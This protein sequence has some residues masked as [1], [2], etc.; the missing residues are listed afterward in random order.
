VFA[1]HARVRSAAG[2]SFAGSLHPRLGL[3]SISTP[4]RF[5]FVA[6]FERKKK[7]EA[8]IKHH[9]VITTPL[10]YSDAL[11]IGEVGQCNVELCLSR[12]IGLKA[13][14]FKPFPLL[15][16]NPG[17]QKRAFQMQPAPLTARWTSSSSAAYATRSA[18]TP[19]TCAPRQG[20][21]TLSLGL[22]RS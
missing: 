6:F 14:G 21:L 13:T 1:R 9:M 17:F 18:A 3:S 2:R 5:S 7:H 16:T 19:P 8:K 11:F 15:K 4:V 22:M 10:G 20:S 12:P